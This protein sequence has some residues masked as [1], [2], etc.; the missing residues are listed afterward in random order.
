LINQ[1]NYLEIFQ[2]KLKI[3]LPK[4]SSNFNNIKIEINSL[5]IICYF[6]N[7]NYGVRN[8]V[9]L[10]FKYEN[11]VSNN[12][13]INIIDSIHGEIN[14]NILKNIDNNLIFE[15][16]FDLDKIQQLQDYFADATGVGSLITRPDGSPITAPS[17]F[18]T[19]CNDIIRKTEKGRLN[20]YKSDSELGVYNEKGPNIQK[21]KSGGL[22][23]AGV[24]ITVG[25]KHIANWLIG[26]IKN[27]AVDVNTMLDYAEEIGADTNEFIT[28]LIDVKEMPVEQFDKIANFLF[29]FANQIS[30]LA[31]KNVSIKNM[32]IE[33]IKHETILKENEERLRLSLKATHQGMYDF[34]LITG[35]IVVND[36][37]AIMLG[38][39]PNNFKITF[40]SWL[41]MIHPI[42][43]ERIKSTYNDYIDNKIDEY[44]TE[45]RLLTNNGDWIWILSL[46]KIVEY[47]IDGKPKRMLGTHTNISDKKIFEQELQL[48]SQSL[49]DLIHSIPL[50]LF[51]YQYNEPDLLYL[52]NGNAAAEFLTG[53]KVKDII[54]LEYNQIF[55]NARRDGLTDKFLSVIHTGNNIELED[56]QYNDNRIAGAFRITVFLMPGKKLGVGFYNITRIKKAEQG[57][58]ESEE[59][60]R[61]LVENQNDFVVKLDK[62][63]Q[64]MFVSSSYCKLLGKNESEISGKDFLYFMHPED[65][66]NSVCQLEKL[67]NSPN[68]CYFEHRI[69]TTAGWKWLA[70][71]DKAVLNENSGIEYIIGV[72]RDITVSKYADEALKEKNYHLQFLNTFA[73]EISE[74]NDYDIL[75]GYISK[76]LNDFTS[77][78]FT[79]YSEYD[80]VKKC[81]ITKKI[82]TNKYYLDKGAELI[83]RKIENFETIIS[84]ELFKIFISETIIPVKTFTELTAGYIPDYIDKT[85]KFIIGIDS[86]YSINISLSGELFGVA[87]ISR[88]DNQ[89][90]PNFD[91][92]QS[93]AHIAALSTKRIKAEEQVK[94]LDRGI[95]QSPVL[96][97][98]TNK[99]AKIQ[100]VN[101]YFC[102]VT[103]YDFDELIGRNPRILNSG[104]NPPN[105]F[106]DMWEHLNNGKVWTGELLNKKKN[107]SL[108]WESVVISPITDINGN[109][110]NYIAVKI[111]IT[112]LKKMTIEII[113]Q[114]QKAEEND[115]LK[116]AFLQNM[117]HEFRTPLNG[118]LGFTQLLQQTEISESERLNYASIIQLSGKRLLEIVNNVMEISKIETNQVVVNY[119]NL[120]ICDVLNEKY[121]FYKPIL[122]S[123]GLEF[124][125]ILPNNLDKLQINSDEQKIHQ[126][127]NNL[128]GNAIKF[129][130]IGYIELGLFESEDFI[131][132]YIKDTGIGIPEFQHQRIFERFYQGETKLSRNYEGA[133]LGLSICRGFVDLLG[134]VLG[135]ESSLGNGSLFYFTLP[136]K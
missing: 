58:K 21:C 66:L 133:G 120:L 96:V 109:I 26:Q 107:G 35:E 55:P 36:E 17:N 129:T 76:K 102:K 95:E 47:T 63:K 113:E 90:V 132:I 37:Y 4:S 48:S 134:G 28:A 57:L 71:S 110:T 16:I 69:M 81:L 51:I 89:A 116:T 104:Q 128:I 124:K 60:Y 115:K 27:D 68:V 73:S 50:G 64:F 119:S 117:S 61:L 1:T 106:K 45:F 32:L 130:E 86:F 105:T 125:L 135:V 24:S 46:G 122:D 42:D 118:I 77:S 14:Q 94:L 123:K 74:I 121:L 30:D 6:I 29:Y 44:R 103:G 22:W 108:Y 5:S 75:I 7:Y 136:K 99:D 2:N 49:N 88:N 31:Y 72:G 34:N 114:K 23:D 101:P 67:E 43:I 84:E 13:N 59:R 41:S 82:L 8:L 83:G 19:L 80:K 70:W 92:I 131:K 52:I 9:L 87:I 93:F 78:K 11:E 39:D 40:D 85:L 65:V 126:I 62:N 98:I 18:C 111:D 3:E 25:N 15:E 56:I 53:L 20:C 91:V 10:G 54:G 12:N 97:V 100:Y 38:Y 33:N 127:L 79:T 112:E